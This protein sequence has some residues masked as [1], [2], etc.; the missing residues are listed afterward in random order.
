MSKHRV[1]GVSVGEYEPEEDVRVTTFQDVAQLF[2]N[3]KTKAAIVGKADIVYIGFWS[4]FSVCRGATDFI[5][6]VTHIAVDDVL[7]EFVVFKEIYQEVN[8][9]VGRNPVGGQVVAS[10]KEGFNGIDFEHQRY[11]RKIIYTEAAKTR[12]PVDRSGYAVAV[13]SEKDIQERECSIFF[14][15]NSE[16]EASRSITT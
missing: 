16:F 3:G 7:W 12:F 14:K 15:F 6:K 9:S 11:K 5:E 8:F 10:I 13:S 4:S 1:Y 2:P